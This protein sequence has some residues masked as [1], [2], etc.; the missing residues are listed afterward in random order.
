MPRKGKKRRAA[1]LREKLKTEKIK[2]DSESTQSFPSEYKEIR[3][4]STVVSG[5]LHQGDTR[6]EYPGVQCTF[7]SFY[8]LIY[9]FDHPPQVWTFADIDT[10]VIDGNNRFIQHCKEQNMHPQMLLAK[11]LPQKV[12]IGDRTFECFQSDDDIK[13]GALTGIA[14]DDESGMITFAEAIS[15]SLT[16][17]QSCLLFCGGLTVAMAQHESRIYVFDPHSRGKNG[18]LHP[19]GSAVLVSFPS[20]RETIL[21][22]E[23]LFT[24]SLRVSSVEQ[25]ELVPFIIAKAESNSQVATTSSHNDCRNELLETIIPKNI[26]ETQTESKVFATIHADATELSQEAMKAYFEDQ[27]MRDAARREQSAK[28]MKKM[29]STPEGLKKNRET[30]AK[31][32]KRRRSTSEGHARNR[33]SGCKSMK[34]IRNTIEGQLKNRE[35]AAKAMKRKRSTSEGLVKDRESRCNSM[36]RIR[37]TP[38]GQLKN[39]E[40][41]AK[42]MRRKRSTTEGL[43]K[44]RESRC[45]SM[46][47]IR[48]TAEGQFKNRETAGKA[49]KRKRSTSEGQAKSR[50][51]GLRSMKRKRNSTEGDKR[52]KTQ[53]KC[54]ICTRCQ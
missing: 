38:E 11:E 12:S 28:R 24:Q 16:K 53:P 33:E 22:L 48:N 27:Y 49:M 31:A 18:L 51:S 30:A 34:R 44:S 7:I 9:M 2:N 8:A 45:N 40:T 13:F 42:A 46:K 50:E 52:K 41:A 15:L 5:S 39:R 26:S 1:E 37:N 29:R 6:F 3:N 35:K 19:E 47:R 14:V 20:I 54:W 23:T 25:F 32:M 21:F 10:C 17:F 43:V 4:E 36:K